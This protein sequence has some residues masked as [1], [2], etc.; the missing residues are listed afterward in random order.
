MRIL[1]TPVSTSSNEHV[2][3]GREE[4]EHPRYSPPTSMHLAR[5][6]G[7]QEKPEFM[8]QINVGVPHDRSRA[9][10][11]MPPQP[12]VG[13]LPNPHTIDQRNSD[14]PIISSLYKTHIYQ[15]ASPAHQG[16]PRETYKVM[17]SDAS[18]RPQHAGSP[19]FAPGQLE[20]DRI[21]S[22]PYAPRE[23]NSLTRS[24]S[25]PP[26]H[27]RYSVPPNQDLALIERP[28]MGTQ[29]PSSLVGPSLS[30]GDSLLLLL[31]VG[32]HKPLQRMFY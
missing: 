5:P 31:Q 3:M 7:I 8:K 10:P 29:S 18:D 12:M 32:F 19:S 16:I 22:S 27:G 11:G 15:P 20:R 21:V 13:H 25:P 2:I 28:R 23:G 30:Q 26:A 1:S 4:R 24:Y 14:S 17:Y 6:P 9:L